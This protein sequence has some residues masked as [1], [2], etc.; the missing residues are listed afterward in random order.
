M[1]AK[2]YKTEQVTR[3]KINDAERATIRKVKLVSVNHGCYFDQTLQIL[4]S[5]IGNYVEVIEHDERF[6]KSVGYNI[7]FLIHKSD[8]EIIG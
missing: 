5:N 4:K 2:Q 1:Q 8:C 3:Q 7:I 6:Y